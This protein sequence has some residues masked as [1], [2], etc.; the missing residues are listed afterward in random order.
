[1]DEAIWKPHTTVAAL[2]ERDGYFL[3][4]LQCI[5]DYLSKPPYPLDVISHIFP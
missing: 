2:C 5:D 1:M 4:V 3:L